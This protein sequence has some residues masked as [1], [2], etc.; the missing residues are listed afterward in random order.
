MSGINFNPTA[1]ELRVFASLQVVFFGLISWIVY[2]QGA[3]PLMPLLIM[4]VSIA[5]GLLGVFRP[6]MIRPIYVVWM[7]AVYPLGWL[8]THTILAIVYYLVFTPM[9]FI[10]RI[11]GH[12]PLQ[13]KFDRE[14][15]TYWIA[16]TPAADS[17]RYFRRY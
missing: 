6:L 15:K 4:G 1:R 9:G 12:D 3:V 7:T 2:R 5:I 14:A 17:E 16:R 8:I 13:R 10:M 11:L